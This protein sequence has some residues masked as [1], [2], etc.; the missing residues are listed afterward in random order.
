MV[1]AAG[2]RFA[3]VDV[4]QEI[5]EE[6]TWRQVILSGSMKLDTEGERQS[7]YMPSVKME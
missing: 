7:Q 2:K 4:N 1:H 6:T 3:I 5:M